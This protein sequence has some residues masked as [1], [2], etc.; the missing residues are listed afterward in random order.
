MNDLA[1]LS[2][3]AASS[4]P[5]ATAAVAASLTAWLASSHVFMSANRCLS[6]WYDARGRPN[7]YRSNA[8]S[9][10]ISKAVCIAPTDSALLMARARSSCRST[11]SP[12]APTSPTRPPSSGTR[13]S[14]KETTEKRRVRST[15]CMGAMDTPAVPAGTSTCVSPAPVRPVTSRW[16]ALAPD[17]TGRLTPFRTTS[18][19]STRASRVTVPSRSSGGGS[20]RHHVAIDVPDMRPPSTASCSSPPTS[21]SVAATTL[22]TASGPGAA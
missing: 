13:T 8:H 16:S 22:V 11:C 17:S 21:E 7:E 3:S 19:P 1:A 18:S 5:S 4:E 14:S 6:S 10:V 9:T 12:A 2:S 20:L 15:D